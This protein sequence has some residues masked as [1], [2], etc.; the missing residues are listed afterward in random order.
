MENV[1]GRIR[2]AKAVKHISVGTLCMPLQVAFLV[3][4][5]S[6]HILA[7]HLAQVTELRVIY[8]NFGAG[9]ERKSNAEGATTLEWRCSEDLVP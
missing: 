9:I 6:V 3:I 1:K 8:E 4:L 2:A 5:E 7:F